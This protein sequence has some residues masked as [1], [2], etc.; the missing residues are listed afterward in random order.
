MDNIQIYNSYLENDK[1]NLK[2]KENILTTKS[3][4][5]SKILS[6]HFDKK[7]NYFDDEKINYERNFCLNYKIK[8]KKE[9]WNNIK[10]KRKQE[11]NMRILENE[12]QKNLKLLYEKNNK[13][14]IEKLFDKK[15]KIILLI[16]KITKKMNQKMKKIKYLNKI[17]YIL[18][19]FRYIR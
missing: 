9:G 16:L 11:D 1:I 4:P 3:V 17:R 18:I 14:K 5:L 10:G 15:M 6:K 13:E 8:N 2:K 7:N 19:F 12:Y